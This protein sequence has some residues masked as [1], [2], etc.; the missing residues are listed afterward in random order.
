MRHG[1]R[2]IIRLALV[3]AVAAGAVSYTLAE[4]ALT[5]SN[6]TVIEPAEITQS[7][8]TLTTTS[9]V[10]GLTGDL[11]IRVAA[12]VASAMED[13]DLEESVAG[14]LDGNPVNSIS[15]SNVDALTREGNINV[16]IA[17]N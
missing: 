1:F 14:V 2:S 3:A 5:S 15:V 6:A 8:V 13:T 7:A 9:F 10:S 12:A 4:K 16:I 17:Y 11:S